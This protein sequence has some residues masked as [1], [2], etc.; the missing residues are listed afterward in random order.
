[1][2]PIS[3]TK[4]QQGFALIEL[5]VVIVIAGLVSTYFIANYESSFHTVQFETMVQKIAADV[6][7]ARDIA[8]S[9]G[10]SV[11]V[12]I[13]P[14]NNKYFLKWADGNYVK[15]PYG[16]E[17]FIIQ[18]GAGEFS[19]VSLTG[20]AFSGGRLDFDTFGKPF[21]AGNDF[22]GTLSLV[23]V[24]SQKQIL[25]SANTGFLQIEEL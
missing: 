17:N 8:M 5:I 9:H 15:N 18:L 14:S 21:N 2:K 19:N 25:V 24:N 23:S 11:Y 4:S 16:G 3:K 6:R 13:E 1:M 20:T 22:T 7:Y 12:H 10:Q